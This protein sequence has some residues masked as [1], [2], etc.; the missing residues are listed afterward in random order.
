MAMASVNT[1]LSQ[2]IGV[3]VNGSTY[4]SI[5]SKAVA[6]DMETFFILEATGAAAAGFA[7]VAMAASVAGEFA[8]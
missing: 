4:S 5:V 3:V 2:E 1:M 7:V 6:G 8:S